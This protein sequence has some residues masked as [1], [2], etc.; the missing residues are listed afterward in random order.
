MATNRIAGI[1]IVGI[2]ILGFLTVADDL[3]HT[4]EIV[5]VASFVLAGG[6]LLISTAPR[7]HMTTG[8]ARSCGIGI[9]LG[10]I[11]GAVLDTM[12]IGV[13][14]GL[15]AGIVAGVVMTRKGRVTGSRGA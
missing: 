15:C 7:V 12:V 4:G 3:R 10:V 11:L 2:G 14:V 9:L 1:L 8:A 5:G 6:I 13:A